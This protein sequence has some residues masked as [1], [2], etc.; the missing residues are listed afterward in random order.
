[1]LYILPLHLLLNMIFMGNA[2][3]L[4]ISIGIV[5]Y[6]VIEVSIVNSKAM[7]KPAY[8]LSN[9]FVYFVLQMYLF[10]KHEING[11]I[12]MRVKKIEFISLMYKGSFAPNFPWVGELSSSAK[13][14]CNT[15]GTKN[16]LIICSGF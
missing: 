15:F 2:Y 5:F 4:W 11:R 10:A 12:S 3:F 1:M 8:F 14:Y 7:Y 16:C 9:S 6:R 13:T